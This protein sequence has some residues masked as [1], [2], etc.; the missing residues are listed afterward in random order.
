MRQKNITRKQFSALLFTALLSPLF[1]LLPR[2]AA[3]AA[4][5]AAWLS[6]FPALPGLL[7]LLALTSA[8]RRALRPGE[9]AANLFLRV[10][11]PGV[12]RLALLLYA[13]WFL[14]YAGF[15]LRSGAERL[16]AAVYRESGMEPFLLVM[17]LLCAVA[18]LGP[19]RAV[20]RTAVPLR[21]VLLLVLGLVFLASLSNLSRN[22]LFPLVLSTL[23]DAAPGALPILSVGGAAALFSFL[24]GY[25]DPPDRPVRWI[26]PSFALFLLVAM[27][28]CLET[29]GSFGPGLTA[30]LSY[31][32]FTML[33][34]V[35]IFHIAQRFEAV[36][37]AL[38][39][40]ADFILCALLLRCAHEAL[41]TI[42]GL[43]KPEGEPMRSLRRGRWLYLPEFAAVYAAARLIAPSAAALARWSDTIVP[44]TMDAFIFGGF[45]MLWLVGK[46][47][48]RL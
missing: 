9:G 34:D 1:R 22:N 35:S 33:R 27:L 37:V 2:A 16:A 44:L 17:L 48:K 11:G 5:K 15:V 43:P 6:V 7:L 31:P 36:V 30:R 20:A 8:L 46:L 38:W 21:A 47:R 23:P 25:V 41:R 19:I 10:L 26:I 12:G 28:L 45:G 42:L 40:F 24:S 29:V 39:V 14:F 3:T 13:A 18:A 32:F 4:G